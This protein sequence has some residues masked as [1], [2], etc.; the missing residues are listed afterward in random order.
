MGVA[1]TAF[2]DL[3]GSLARLPLALWLALDDVH[4]KYRRTVLGPLWITLG[5]AMLIAG[6][7]VVFSGLF[8]MEPATYLL[9]LAAGFPVWTLLSQFLVDMPSA[10]VMS[11][12][13]IESYQLP[14][15][16]YIW[17]RTFAYVLTF[18]HHIVILFVVMAILRI[19]PTTAMLLAIPA[20]LVVAVAGAGVGLVLAVIGARYRDLQPAMSMSAGVLMLLSPVVWRAEQ[21]QVNEWV[22][23]FNPLYYFIR[24]LRDPLLNEVSPIEIWIGTSAGAIALFVLGFLVFLGARRRL[25][26]WL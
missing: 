10:F 6:F 1:A 26:H 7:A 16:T 21:L 14:W 4:G 17:R 19:V 20:L 3:G 2:R 25:Y 9:Y 13:M 15:L 24:L 18:L 11:K 23:R 12:G 8:G 5:Q 22:V